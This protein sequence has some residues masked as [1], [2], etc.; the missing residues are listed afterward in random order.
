[1]LLMGA[2]FQ[3]LGPALTI[4]A[5]LGHKDPFVLP[6]DRKEAADEAKQRFAGESFR[7]GFNVFAMIVE[8]FG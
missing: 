1:M 5:A 3:C 4:A 6:I 2:I 8:V 7:S